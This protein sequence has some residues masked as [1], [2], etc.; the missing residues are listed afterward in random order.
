MD[1]AVKV[2]VRVS[3][4]VDGP[5][6]GVVFVGFLVRG[7]LHL[8]HMIAPLVVLGPVVQISLGY[9]RIVVVVA[10]KVVPVSVLLVLIF[11][12]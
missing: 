11:F 5:L 2:A 8:L 12:I 9:L 7:L 1:R 3:A 6:G 10:P 4:D